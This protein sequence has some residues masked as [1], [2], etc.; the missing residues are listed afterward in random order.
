MTIPTAPTVHG[1]TYD[2]AYDP[3]ASILRARGLGASSGHGS[4][5]DLDLRAGEV[6]VVLGQPGSGKRELLD[7]VSGAAPLTS[8]TARLPETVATLAAAGTSA[9][10]ASDL[11]SALVLRPELVTANEPYR[12]LDALARRNAHRQLRAAAAQ[13]GVTVLYATN[14]VHEAIALADRI[15]LLSER[16]VLRDV[17]V[18]RSRAATAETAYAYLH[19][20]LLSDLGLGP[21]AVA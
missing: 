20:L 2:P 3:A 9:Q 16:R 14:D 1:P 8:G 10:A 15:I 13:Q 17:V 5:I 11:A 7:I 18:R 19:A 12:T 4:G 21:V 6:V